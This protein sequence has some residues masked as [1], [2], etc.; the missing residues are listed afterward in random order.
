MIDAL[1]ELVATSTLREHVL[2]ALMNVPGLPPIAQAIHILSVAV[3]TASAIMVALR[4]LNLA[5]PSQSP[6]EMIGRLLPWTWWALLVLFATGILFVIARPNRYFYNPI[7]LGKFG[8]LAG[9]VAL[10]LVIY[11]VNKRAPGFWEETRSHLY[12]ARGLAFVSLLLWVGVIFAGR[13][14]AYLDYLIY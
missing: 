14:I 1:A 9:A 5:V 12:A 11:L 13:W 2:W 3:V 8:L 10:T 7:A 4:F 6:S